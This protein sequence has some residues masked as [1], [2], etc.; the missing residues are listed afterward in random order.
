MRPHQ[1]KGG[2]LGK[3]FWFTQRRGSWQEGDM[4]LRVPGFAGGLALIGIV[5]PEFDCVPGIRCPRLCGRF[6]REGNWG[7]SKLSP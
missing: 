5:S 4:L 2:R 7:F 3:A 1:R 6:R